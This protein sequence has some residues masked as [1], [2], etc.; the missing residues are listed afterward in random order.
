M[1]HV[2]GSSQPS[3]ACIMQK[4]WSVAVH[5]MLSGI[6]T[7]TLTMPVMDAVMM[8]DTAGEVI[9]AL[10]NRDLYYVTKDKLDRPYKVT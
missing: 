1:L 3:E 10:N 7:A 2:L 9:W 8:Q 4:T 6:S 5:C